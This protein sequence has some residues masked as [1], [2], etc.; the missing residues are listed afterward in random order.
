MHALIPAGQHAV[1]VT[2]R[3]GE[4]V[5]VAPPACGEPEAVPVDVVDP[6]AL[7]D[8]EGLAEDEDVAEFEDEALQC[9]ANL[10]HR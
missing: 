3:Q 4:P 8:A 9:A 5:L 10:E 6:A 2:I 1:A 7:G